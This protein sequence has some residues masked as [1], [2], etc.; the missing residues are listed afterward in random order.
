MLD[1]RYDFT[2]IEQR[3][4]QAWEDNGCYTPP[5]DGRKP[6]AIMMPPP[7]VTGALHI[8]HALD[9]TLPDIM[10]R[11]ARM[12]GYDALYQPGTDHASI[13][14]HVVLERGWAKEGKSRFD[15]GREKFLEKAWE[16]KDYSA[17]VI[18]GQLRRLGISCDW[19][20]ERFMMD[21]AYCVAVVKAFKAL[22]DKGLIYRGQRLVNW[23]PKMQTAVSDLEVKHKEVKGNLWHVSYPFANGAIYA[24]KGGIEIATTRPETIL[25]DGAIAIHP[26]DP[27][28]GELVGR[29]VV[30]PIVE[31]E[32][33]IVA[34]EMVDPEFG[35]GMVKITPAHD[36]NDFECY[37]RRK[38][39]IELPLIN[40][41]N[42]NGTLNHNV[43]KEYQGLDRFAARKKVAETLEA[44]GALLKVEPHVHNVGHAE[45]DDTI[46][47]P[48]LTW[49]WYV[50]TGPIAKKCLAAAD[51][52]EVTFVNE[53]DEKVYR[54]WLEN[55]QDWCISRQLWWGHRIPAWYKDVPGKDEP[56]IHVGEDAPAGEGWRQDDD[57]LDTWFSSALWPFA[58][59]GW[60][61][62][63]ERLSH[64]YP[65]S[66]IMSGRDILFFWLI[67]MMMMGLELTDK[68]PFKKIY[69]HGMILDEH[70]QKM[71]KSKG[72]VI[73]PMGLIEQFG[74]D[75]LRL[76]M[77]SIASAEDM[78]LSTAKVEQSR[79]FCTKLWNAARFL[80]MQGVRHASGA[81]QSFKVADVKHPVN[82]WVIGELKALFASVDARLD[83][84]EFNQAAQ[85]LYHFTWGTWCDWYLEAIK[86]LVNGADAAIA[87]ETRAVAGWAFEKLLVALHPVIPF[88]TEEIWQQHTMAENTYLI[89][90]A[91]PN[92]GAWQVDEAKVLEMRRLFNLMAALRQ[93]RTLYKLS[94][95]VE[96]SVF[97]K[98]NSAA[99]AAELQRNLPMLKAIAGVKE[100]TVR[101]GNQ[102]KGEAVVVVDGVDYA[103]PLEGLVDLAAERERLRKD[104]D[105]QVAELQKISGLLA[106]EGFVA[107]APAE[108]IA[109]QRARHA[110]LTQNIDKI[111][112]MLATVF[113]E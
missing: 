81:E 105:K 82:L 54:H 70:G 96:V 111:K 5:M 7:N 30:V 71:S 32:I 13:A 58:T 97:V 51:K 68:V 6:F 12:K 44:S 62:E 57:I 31:R 100:V 108:A 63:G 103:M 52:G 90:R 56:E 59:Q 93:A 39:E 72:N 60:P 29:K 99:V 46:L 21:P 49:Q 26:N 64:F 2:L 112:E 16:W 28:A 67:R 106:N 38:D 88:I 43:P 41:L 78:R 77:A 53:R 98:E 101:G 86:P 37:K 20:N 11:R 66:V 35:S 17:G 25:A 19:S 15:F 83:A 14:V 76:T 4:A 36:F 75:A 73:D 33:Y 50:K 95:K 1:K 61:I 107:K 55:I 27:R 84:Y 69:T 40:M 42:P 94:P 102:P 22:Y 79:N 109:Q 45:R 89:G 10:V 47:E 74:T 18:T 8:G 92:Y 113:A 48:Y 91:W 65:G 24:G 85:E 34:D 110:E 104:M 23:D 9:N 3:Y 80:E 87:E